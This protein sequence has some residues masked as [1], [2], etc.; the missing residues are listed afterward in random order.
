MRALLIP[1]VCCA[2]VVG[3]CLTEN[4]EYKNGSATDRGTWYDVAPGGDGPPPGHDGPGPVPDG[5]RPPPPHD[6]PKPPPDKKPP[7]PPPDFGPMTNGTCA[8]AKALTWTGV[9]I[10]VKGTTSGAKNEYGTGVN[11]G[12]YATVMAARQVYYSVPLSAG[13][14]YR[15]ILAPGYSY[16][17]LILFQ[18]CGVTGMNADCA[19]EGKTGDVSPS[20][21]AGK[22][23]LFLFKP[24]KSGTWIVA[25]DG[26]SNSRHGPFTLSVEKYKAVANDRCASAQLL[27]FKGGDA[28][29]TGHTGG[30]SNEYGSD[31]HCGHSSYRYAGGQVYYKVS[32]KAG[33]T[34]SFSLKPTFYAAMYLFKS[35]NCSPSGINGDC[36]SKG[37][38]G[39]FDYYVAPNQSDSISFTPASSAE[40]TIAI[41]SRY[42]S[43][44]GSFTLNVKE[45][46]PKNNEDCTKATPL[47]LTGGKLAVNGDTKGLKNEYG[48][49]VLCGQSSASYAFDG[50]QQYYSVTLSAGK[51]YRLSLTAFFSYG[52]LILFGDTCGDK[53]INAD[54]G[55][56]GAAGGYVKTSHSKT[57]YLLF[58]PKATGKFHLA[59]DSTSSSGA[60][61]Y[62]LAV[63]EVQTPVNGTCAKAQAVTLAPKVTTTVLGDTTS[64]PNEFGTQVYC[65]NYTTVLP[66]NQAYFKLNLT[67]GQKYDFTL[68]PTFS[69]ARFYLFGSSCKPADINQD[70]GSG[71]KTG[72]ISKSIYANYSGSLSWTPPKTGVY[73]LAVDSTKPT[74]KGFFT[75]QIK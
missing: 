52:A 75:L 31:I 28:T 63:E 9:K 20:I 6:G 72:D 67:G 1:L 23:G 5:W 51:T 62:K 29:V 22:T 39:A 3:S 61:P 53:A 68:K 19:S 21:S 16:A 11:C 46:Q 2:L 47:S 4:P 24:P 26:T 42:T 56:K 25:V 49:G 8:K 35:S 17:R 12:D 73:H 74:Q 45:Y 36:S 30:A 70:C 41:D 27:T 66:G 71:G 18:K 38:T 57:G 37:K 64:M 33:L 43:Y 48:N 69:D 40:Y 54:C 32:M 60:G 10:T 50:P 59:V 58:T 65:G 34:Y 55:S 14:T 7:P 44:A 15:F 13:D